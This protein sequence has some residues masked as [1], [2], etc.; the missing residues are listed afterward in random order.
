MKAKRRL[1]ILLVVTLVFSIVSA[2]VSASLTVYP[3][4]PTTPPYTWMYVDDYEFV[5]DLDITGTTFD[6]EVEIYN[7]SRLGDWQFD[8]YYNTTL[9]NA[10]TCSL[11]AIS[12]M[13][14]EGLLPAPWT[15]T[16]GIND[17]AGKVV[18]GAGYPSAAYYDTPY[19]GSGALLKVTFVIDYAPPYTNVTSPE[20]KS[21]SCTLGL[22]VVGLDSLGPAPDYTITSI[23]HGV[24]NGTYTWIRPQ[25]VVGA[26]TAKCSVYPATQYVCEN[27]TFDGSASEDGGAPPLYYAWDVNS[28]G[29]YEFNSTNPTT[30]YHCAAAGTYNVTLTVTNY[31]N[32]S[33]TAAPQTWECI[34]K[35]G[36]IID[37]YT[38]PNRWCGVDTWSNLTGEGVGKGPDNPCDAL[39]QE[40]NITLYAEVTYNGAPV[41]HVFVAFEVLWEWEIDWYNITQQN[42]PGLW[43][44]KNSCV[45]YAIAETN[46][47]GIA[48]ISFRVPTPCEEGT[49]I[50]KWFAIVKCKVQEVTIDDTMRFD[51]GYLVMLLD[52]QTLPDDT[53]IRQ[54]DSLSVEILVKS[55]A[56]I[57]RHAVFVFVAYDE[58]NVP[59]G[60]MINEL[61]VP[62]GYYCDP[63]HVNISWGGLLIPQYAYVGF[64]RVEVSVFTAKPSECGIPYS[65]PISAPIVIDWAP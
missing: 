23:T 39:S 10:T 3:Y 43:V 32:M 40:V 21:V 62:P 8:L 22:D 54:V 5:D 15:P 16:K 36:P 18:F 45:L 63:M 52:I 58:C 20:N 14:T 12:N 1:P 6:V 53:F 17:P 35:L 48:Q 29:S 4:T 50:G 41:N 25:K 59:I 26:P 2:S 60:Q 31:M 38:S 13:Y 61:E 47:D 28:D 56:W 57:P 7:V 46:K 49:Y 9:L 44:S 11:T 24:H 65:K 30:S 55:I 51:V 42:D 33:H 34:E 64:G 27:V 37:L 19:N